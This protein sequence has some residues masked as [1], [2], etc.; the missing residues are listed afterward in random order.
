MCDVSVI[1]TAYNESQA[2]HRAINSAL[3]QTFENIEIIIIDDNST[4]DT[5]KL[6]KEYS[7]IDKI[8]II[9]HKQN[10]GGSAARNTGIE[11]A[12][13][14]Y[15]AL[16]DGDDRWK[17]RK[18]T[19]Q[20]E[21]IESSSNDVV[22]VYCDFDIESQGVA[23]VREKLSKLLI[24]DADSVG[25][26][27]IPHEGG[28]ELI[29]YILSMQF[30]LGGSS[31]LLIKRSIAEEIGGFDERFPRHQDWEFLI[32]LL[33]QGSI[34]RVDQKLVVK[35]DDDIH[36]SQDIFKSKRLF[37]DKFSE[38]I[39]NSQQNEFDI[40]GPHIRHLSYSY[41]QDGHFYQGFKCISGKESLGFSDI[42][43]LC[44]SF[45]V[46]VFNVLLNSIF[47]LIESIPTSQDRSRD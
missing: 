6:I 8:T 4:D 12:S 17:P 33:K 24:S 44:W 22:A 3:S 1:I 27:S 10:R 43:R 37:F 28:S 45:V 31:T 21:L 20:V 46:G 42:K 18:I 29:P 23:K 5:L 25:S 35:Y 9:K 2:I 7:C 36:S 30:R 26:N 47:V 13:G 14:D 32:R 39:Y 41:L 40:L 19:K 11:A 34:R 16:L 15:I 38:E